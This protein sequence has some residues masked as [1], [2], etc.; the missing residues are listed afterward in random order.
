MTIQYEQT[1]L[2]EKLLLQEFNASFKCV[3]GHFNWW[4]VY[5]TIV[6]GKNLY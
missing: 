2:T 6:P 1:V 3:F 4:A 5:L